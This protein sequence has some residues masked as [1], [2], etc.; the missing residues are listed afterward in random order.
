MWAAD[1]AH[2]YYDRIARLYEKKVMERKFKVGEMVL[3][4][5]MLKSSGPRSKLSENWEGPYV[6]KEAYAGNA[7]QLVDA[8]GVE[9]SHPW[10]GVYLK[11]F[12]P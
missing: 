7:Y 5:K 9:L 4:R 3:K 6:V 12:F 2:V 10:N 11:K 1:H 8:N